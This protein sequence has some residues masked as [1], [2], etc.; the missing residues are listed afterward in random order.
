M[1]NKLSAHQNVPMSAPNPN[2]APNRNPNR[3]PTPNPN[4]NRAPNR[5]RNLNPQSLAL[6]L[7]L[8]RGE[9]DYDYE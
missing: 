9:V 7:Y 8:F 3:N 2:R 4:R 5:T 1:I 6:R